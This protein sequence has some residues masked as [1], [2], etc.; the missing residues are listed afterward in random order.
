[1]QDHDNEDIDKD[2]DEEDDMEEEGRNSD[3]E[4]DGE[5]DDTMEADE[6]EQ[7][8]EDYWDFVQEAEHFVRQKDKKLKKKLVK[9]MK[10]Y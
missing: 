3:D 5:T 2:D 1:M 7:F 4:D 10:G 8:K 6:I 9:K